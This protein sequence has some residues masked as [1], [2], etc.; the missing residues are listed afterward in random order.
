[1]IRPCLLII[2][3][4]TALPGTAGT[5]LLDAAW[6]APAENVADVGRGVAIVFTPDLSVDGNCRFYQALGFAC[7]ED[8]SW[9]R[10]IDGI[11]AFN[12][13]NPDRPV[14]TVLLETHGTNGATARIL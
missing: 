10:V 3:L 12:E 11:H 2:V 14:E 6:P 7:F 5:S 4:F 8:S 9:T 1:M 13:S